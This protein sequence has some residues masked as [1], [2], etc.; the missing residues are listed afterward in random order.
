MLYQL[1]SSR[2]WLAMCDSI[3]VIRWLRHEGLVAPRAW[4]CLTRR[5]NIHTLA[6]P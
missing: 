4:L 3:A 5:F 1:A 2:A 6:L